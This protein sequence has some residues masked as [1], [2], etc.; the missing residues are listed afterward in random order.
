LLKEEEALALLHLLLRSQAKPPVFASATALH[1]SL[2]V[3]GCTN[4]EPQRSGVCLFGEMW[5]ERVFN[6]TH[7]IVEQPKF[8]FY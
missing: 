8:L 3:A 4:A 7:Q 6:I 1:C 5:K 2:V